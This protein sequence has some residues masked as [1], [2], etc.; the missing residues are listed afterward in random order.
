M[1][2]M[3]SLGVTRFI[4][5][6]SAGLISDEFDSSHLLLVE[7]AI[8]DEGTSY[9]YLP[10]GEKAYTSPLL[11]E[12]VKE[13]LTR[14]GVPF[15]MGRIWSTDA[16]YRETPARVARRKAQGAVAVD[17]E[18]SA[19][20]AVAQRR[21]VSFTQLMYFSDFLLADVWSGFVPAYGDLRL[22]SLEILLE[23]GMEVAGLL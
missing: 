19:L 7:D 8:R 18:C 12:Q 14:Q 6:G 15:D 13:S 23:T 9:Q 20:C 17:M 10:A 16:L 2:E 5:C 3:I 21:G 22:K 1:D 11:N 4:S